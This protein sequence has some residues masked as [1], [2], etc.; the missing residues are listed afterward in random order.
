[1]VL[2]NVIMILEPSAETSHYIAGES[3]ACSQGRHTITIG[4]INNTAVW[5]ISLPENYSQNGRSAGKSDNSS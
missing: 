5:A 1:M 4:I 3:W 2:W